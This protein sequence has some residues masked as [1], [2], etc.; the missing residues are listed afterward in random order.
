MPRERL[1]VAAVIYNR[2]KAGMPLGIDAT[3]RYGFD[4]PPTQAI[5]QSQLDSDNPY[6]TRKLPG[7]LPTPIANP[8]SPRSRR[9][10]TWPRSTSA[11]SCASP[12]AAVISFTASEAEF[13]NFPRGGLQC[14]G[15]VRRASS[16][17]G[18]RSETRS[19]RRCRTP[20]CRRLGSTGPMSRCP[21]SRSARGR[22]RRSRRAGLPG[23]ERHHPA[24]DRCAR[25]LRRARRGRPRGG[26]VNTLVIREGRVL[27]SSTDG[28]AVTGA[29]EAER[30]DALVLGAGAA[31]AV[32]T[33][34]RCRLCLPPCRRALAREGGRSPA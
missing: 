21:S 1:L 8:G 11:T 33:A 13:N 5:L 3:V 10:R 25:L 18:T 31:Q 24:Q 30:V 23:R 29:V 14:G 12:T 28:L 19:R 17:T 4:I 7:L 27:G 26:S 20:P 22:G 32:A 34:L 9:R 15:R 6:N 16:A 2:L